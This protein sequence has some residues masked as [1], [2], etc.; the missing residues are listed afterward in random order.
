MPVRQSVAVLCAFLFAGV[1]AGAELRPMGELAG[2]VEPNTPSVLQWEVQTG[3]LPAKVEYVIRDYVEREVSRGEIEHVAG[4]PLE[5]PV[6]LS[7]GF[8]DVQ[9]TGTA[10]RYGVVALPLPPNEGSPFFCIDAAMSW[11]VKDDALRTAMIKKL[12]RCGIRTARERLSWAAINPAKDTY[13]WETGARYD[14]LRKAYQANGIRVLEVFHDAPAWTGRVGKYPDDLAEAVKAWRAIRQQWSSNWLGLEVW[15]EPDIFFGGDMPADQYASML[16]ALALTG[17]LLGQ[18]DTVGG[19]FAHYNRAFL[20]GAAENGLPRCTDV[21]SFHTYDRAPSMA[22][23]VGGYRKSPACAGASLWLTECGRPWKKGPP[24]PPREE[25]AISALDITMK[26]VEAYAAGVERYFAFVYPYY[27]ENDNNFGMMDP[28]GT[29]LRSMAAYARLATLLGENTY[30]V[31]GTL[32]APRGVSTRV[33]QTVRAPDGPLETIAVVYTGRIDA[34]ATIRLNIRPLRVEGIDGRALELA[35]DGTIPVPDGLNYVWLNA[36]DLHGMPG[37]IESTDALRRKCLPSDLDIRLRSAGLPSVVLRFDWD[38]NA[39]RPTVAGYRVDMARAQRVTLGVRAFNLGQ[40]EQEVTLTLHLDE[41]GIKPLDNAGPWKLKLAGE[42]SQTVSMDAD[43]REAFAAADVV[44]VRVTCD[45]PHAARALPLVAR[46][47]GQPTLAQLLTRYPQHT[48]L[49]IGDLARWQRGAPGHAT[50]EM[51]EEKGAWKLKVQFGEGD[52]WCYPRFTLPNSVDLSKSSALVLRARCRE[53]ATVRA[54]LWEDAHVGYVSDQSIIPA[55]A[56][57][58]TAI[59][60]FSQLS[61][62]GAN[63]PDA[64]GRLDLEKVRQIS[65]GINSDRAANLLEVAEAYVV[66]GLE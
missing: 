64:N 63:A 42:S 29:P 12:V 32:E 44:R 50:D 30:C 9:L 6:T 40:E 57:W 54:F 24:R 60:R 58:H 10:Q 18:N 62:S 45:G 7:A 16:K 15:N 39:L 56:E 53:P 37:V 11:L 25:D 51:L 41:T 1:T 33:L 21:V 55:D 23:L 34:A 61:P 4:K 17:E 20:D 38:R 31:P 5:L 52:R 48:R 49:P 36:A 27:E 35:A 65:I 46:L 8:Y 43:L 66:A 22:G 28:Y 19:C 3:K 13:G 14:S 2:F 47:L 26:A 59:V